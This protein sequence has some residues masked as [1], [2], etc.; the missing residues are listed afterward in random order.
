MLAGDGCVGKTSLLLRLTDNVTVA[1]CPVEK[2]IGWDFKIK[3]LT[4]DDRNIK[5]QI[6]DTAGQE[7]YR[8]IA[9]AYYRNSHAILF[10][11]DVT[12]KE[13]FEDIERWIQQVTPDASQRCCMWIIG[14]KIDSHDRV[15][16]TQQLE[17]TI[18]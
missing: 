3:P 5:L 9:K 12:C 2:L 18:Q 14:N 4:I 6:W 10:V 1:E 15:I 8:A 17:V 16:T 11:Y 13:S 7:R